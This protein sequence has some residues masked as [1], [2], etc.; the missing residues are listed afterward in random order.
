MQRERYQRRKLCCF[1]SIETSTKAP[2]QYRRHYVRIYNH[3]AYLGQRE[4]HFDDAKES[5]V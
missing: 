4:G 2:G 1:V 3:V 5:S